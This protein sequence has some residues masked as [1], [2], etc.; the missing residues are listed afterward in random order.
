MNYKL[1]ALLIAC[2]FGPAAVRSQE[3][4]AFELVKLSVE[5]MGVQQCIQIID[6]NREQVWSTV[7]VR[8]RITNVSKHP[9]IIY[10]YSPAMYDARLSRT[11]ADMPARKFQFAER[12]SLSHVPPRNF[13]EAQSTN[14]FR[15]LQSNESFAYNPPDV[16]KFGSNEL[17]DPD[18]RLFEGDYFLQVK[19]ATWVWEAEKAEKLQLRWAG[20]GKFFYDDVT[21][22]PFPITIPKPGAT[23]P[24]CDT[25]SVK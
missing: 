15:I 19:V 12:P 16:L 11:L 24:R 25:L 9:L 21:S 4:T 8:F 3:P 23:T 18:R 6:E 22:E 7:Q 10:R 13:D 20:F 2:M 14:E 5:A 17:E 1:L